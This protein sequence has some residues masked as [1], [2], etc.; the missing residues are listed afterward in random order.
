MMPSI[1]SQRDFVAALLFI[2]VGTLGFVVALNYAP[3]TASAMGP[4]YLPRILSAG[5]ILLGLYVGAKSL[6]QAGPRIELKIWRPIVAVVLAI[7]AFGLLIERTG[8]VVAVL[9]LTIISSFATPDL[10]LPHAIVLAVLLTVFSVTL[11]VYVL[12]QPMQVFWF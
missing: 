5:I 10:K 9:G 3:G 1:R 4:G 7:V 8:L 12:G 2:A 11:F 6:V